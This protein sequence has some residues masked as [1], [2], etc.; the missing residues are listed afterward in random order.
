[1]EFECD[2]YDCAL[3][4]RRLDDIRHARASGDI[5]NLMFLLRAG[6]QTKLLAAVRVS[7]SP[8]L[9]ACSCRPVAHEENIYVIVTRRSVSSTSH[10]DLRV[11]TEPQLR[12]EESIGDPHSQP[13]CMH[14]RRTGLFRNLGNMG[15]PALYTHCNVGTKR[16]IERYNE[17]V[18]RQLE[19]I[20]T[21]NSSEDSLAET[22]D[23]FRDVRLAFG[24][25]ALML[26]GG[27]GLGVCACACVCVRCIRT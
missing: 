21:V 1:M 22:I 10:G 19:Y 4:D 27:G 23:F 15:N 3:I 6:M 8:I 14:A 2:L 12:P 9:S 24:R 25:T 18:V 5:H 13:L 17:E 20:A 26:S 16:L 7:R 11:R